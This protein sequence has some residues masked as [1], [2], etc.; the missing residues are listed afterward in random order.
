MKCEN[1]IKG[2]WGWGGENAADICTL[3]QHGTL[4]QLPTNVLN[5][6]MK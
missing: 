6:E 5:A 1:M 4:Q 2:F 3:S